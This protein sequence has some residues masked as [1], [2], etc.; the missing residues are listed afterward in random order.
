MGN[1]SQRRRVWLPRLGRRDAPV[2]GSPLVPSRSPL[3][4]A[5]GPL[6]VR[7]RTSFLQTHLDA[8][9]LVMP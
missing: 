1:C 3:G 9:I 5:T 8:K 4:P 2:D 7:L 6:T